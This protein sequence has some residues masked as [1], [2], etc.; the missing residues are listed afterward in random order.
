MRLLGDGRRVVS[1]T[2]LAQRLR[3]N[4]NAIA[5]GRVCENRTVKLASDSGVEALQIAILGYQFPD[6]EDPTTRY[7]W[8]VITGQARS[9]EETWTSAS[10]R[11]GRLAF[12]GPNLAFDVA[13]WAAGHVVLDVALDLEFPSPQISTR[14]RVPEPKLLHLTLAP[15]ALPTAATDREQDVARY[16]DLTP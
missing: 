10:T 5:V 11:P 12:T 14:Q 13:G 2:V 8:H 9:T 1:N 7:G 6:A 15:Q 3:V 16:P 4:R